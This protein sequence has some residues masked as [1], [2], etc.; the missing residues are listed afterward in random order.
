MPQLG[1]FLLLTLLLISSFSADSIGNR[2]LPILDCKEYSSI[3]KRPSPCFPGGIS[4]GQIGNDQGFLTYSLKQF[5]AINWPSNDGKI[6]ESGSKNSSIRYF[7]YWLTWYV[8]DTSSRRFYKSSDYLETYRVIDKHCSDLE[9][10][11]ETKHRIVSGEFLIVSSSKSPQGEMLFDRKG[12]EIFY[13]THINPTAFNAY[14]NTAKGT[15]LNFPTGKDHSISGERGAVVLKSAWKEVDPDDPNTYVTVQALILEEDKLSKP[16]NVVE[17]ALISLHVAS[18]MTPLTYIKEFYTYADQ[19]KRKFLDASSWSWATYEH[20]YNAPTITSFLDI[21]AS[22]KQY[23]SLFDVNKLNI[24]MIKKECFGENNKVDLMKL[25]QTACLLNKPLRNKT[26]IIRLNQENRVLN[27]ENVSLQACEKCTK[28]ENGKY[29]DS[30]D[31]LDNTACKPVLDARKDNFRHLNILS[32]YVLGDVQ[33]VDSR[34]VIRPIVSNKKESLLRNTALEPYSLK[35]NCV[36]CHVRAQ[37]G[38]FMFAFVK[39]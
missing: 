24:N 9:L 25:T 17:L 31:Y 12:K 13:K 20:R 29:V 5:Y 27:I 7:P 26:A 35:S 30:C 37:K 1:K 15:K 38:D 23:W 10:N 28:L 32:N 33:W 16:C 18:K 6:I 2:Q 34:G 39:G 19:M 14:I 36:A 11:K 21:Q 8:R 4:R 3:E 22:Q